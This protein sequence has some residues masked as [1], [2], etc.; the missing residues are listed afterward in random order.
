MRSRTLL[1]MLAM[2]C[3]VCSAAAAQEARGTIKVDWD[4]TVLV[5]RSTPTLQVVTN[6]MLNPGSPIHDG[7]FAALKGLGA[8]YVRYVPW[9]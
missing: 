5:S 2:S 4:K 3:I 8:D 9:L 7:S 6:P 1:L